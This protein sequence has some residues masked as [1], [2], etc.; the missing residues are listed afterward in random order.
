MTASHASGPEIVYGRSTAGS[1][2]GSNPEAGPSGFYQGSCILDPRYPYQNGVTGIGSIYGFM[3]S[4]PICLYDGVPTTASATNIAAAQVPVAATA[5]TLA[6]TNVAGV[7][8]NVPLVPYGATAAVTVIGIDL[9]VP[10]GVST[11][12]ASKTITF[13]NA[14]E[15][16]KYAV[17]DQ[18]MIG[19]GA[20]SNLPLF[21]RVTVA[22]ASSAATTL[23]V[24][25]AVG[26]TMSNAAFAWRAKTIIDQP[27]VYMN[28]GTMRVIDP[29]SCLARTLLFT[30]AGNDSSGTA[31]VVGYD[32]YNRLVTQTVTLTNASTVATTKAFKYVLSITPAGTLSGSNLSV[33]FQD[34]F[35][36][37]LR[38]DRFDYLKLVVA[39]ALITATTGFTAAVLTSPSTATTGDV[40]GTYALQTAADN[41]RRTSIWY[42]PPPYALQ[43]ATPDNT[44]P[45]MGQAQV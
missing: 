27:S 14:I 2:A 13:P 10:R 20:G 28:A 45:L 3:N 44:V 9:G 17:G 26:A 15:C 1:S 19:G 43:T 32:I 29:T 11:T 16:N 33:G 36:F 37:A 24:N 30:S 5:L 35:G 18:V 42:T 40:R 6:S 34:T 21:T 12:S 31:T 39:S 38:V 41:S 23:T 22:A 7:C 25:D 4:A 8:C